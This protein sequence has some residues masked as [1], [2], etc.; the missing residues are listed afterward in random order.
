MQSQIPSKYHFIQWSGWIPDFFLHPSNV[1]IMPKKKAG[2]ERSE[3]H[4][5]GASRFAAGLTLAVSARVGG[6]ASS[7]RKRCSQYKPQTPELPAAAVLQQRT[8]ALAEASLFTVQSSTMCAVKSR[9]LSPTHL[10]ITV[11]LNAPCATVDVGVVSWH[12]NTSNREQRCLQEEL[13]GAYIDLLA[14][15]TT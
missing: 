15:R 4:G 7:R 12:N 1:R 11:R 13:Y 3:N 6:S 14:S 2:K 10:Q 8:T 9:D 5:G